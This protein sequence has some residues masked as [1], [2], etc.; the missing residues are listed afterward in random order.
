MASVWMHN[1]Y[2]QVEGKKMSKSDGNFVTIRE[3]NLYYPGDV[4]RYTMLK[5][6][7]RKPIDFRKSDLE[8]SNSEL[9][10]WANLLNDM[11]AFYKTSEREDAKVDAKF[12]KYLSDDLNTSD[13]ISRMRELFFEVADETSSPYDFIKTSEMLGLWQLNMP[14]I[15]NRGVAAYIPQDMQK[16]FDTSYWDILKFRM[17]QAN[18]MEGDFSSLRILLDERSISIDCNELG[19]ANISFNQNETNNLDDYIEKEIENR[20]QLLNDKNFAEADRI[21][22][23]LLEQ[24]IQLKDGKDPETGERVTT[25][26]VKR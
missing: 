5:T 2:V 20:L 16:T 6:H 13:A 23:E 22:D 15:F 12:I 3:Q 17:A 8:D 11:G 24:G 25:W 19:L 26:E 4:S 21:R 1:G 9:S 14:Y 18:Q 10:K 7:Y